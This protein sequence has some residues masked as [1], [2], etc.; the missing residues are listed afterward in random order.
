MLY[1]AGLIEDVGVIH[2][3]V[4]SSLILHCLI[5]LL[6]S[7][8]IFTRLIRLPSSTKRLIK[9]SRCSPTTIKLPLIINSDLLFEM[10][11]DKLIASNDYAAGATRGH[12]WPVT[13]DLGVFLEM[14]DVGEFLLVVHKLELT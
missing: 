12:R 10:L 7:I 4:I 8:R 3:V 9:L 6:I 14:V 1:E 5:M 13:W 11:H 2:T